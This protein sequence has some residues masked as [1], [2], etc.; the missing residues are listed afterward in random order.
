MIRNKIEDLTA[1]ATAFFDNLIVGKFGEGKG[2]GLDS[3]RPFGNSSYRF[4]LL[5]IIGWEPEEEDEYTE[6]QKEY[7]RCLYFDELV[8]FMKRVWQQYLESK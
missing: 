2:I 4:D 8:P 1:I 6:E 5:E 3:K 7:V